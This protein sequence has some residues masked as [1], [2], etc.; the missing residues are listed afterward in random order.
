M[1][2][3]NSTPVGTQDGST[4]DYTSVS[5]VDI[6]NLMMPVYYT[7]QEIT[8][9][10]LE[11][12]KSSWKLVLENK[13]PAYFELKESKGSLCSCANSIEFFCENFYHR[14]F[15]VSPVSRALFRDEIKVQG[16][17]LFAE[18]I[19]STYVL[20]GAKLTKM[21]SIAIDEYGNKTV[22]ESSL[23]RLAEFHNL[24]GVQAVECNSLPLLISLNFTT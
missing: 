19:Q 5:V 11:L 13:C 24:K 8:E 20:L 16:I 17:I 10:E 4:T 6:I 2:S 18:S 3:G 12:V 21:M 15:D 22:F 14:L 7:T 1:G 9:A 23:V